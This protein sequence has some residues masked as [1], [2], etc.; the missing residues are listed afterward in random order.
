[1]DLDYFVVIDRRCQEDWIDRDTGNTTLIAT[2]SAQPAITGKFE[3]RY[4]GES[5]L[6]GTDEGNAPL[7]VGLCI[8][9]CDAMLAAYKLGAEEI[10]LYGADFAMSGTTDGQQYALEKYYFD[11]PSYVGL[12][13]RPENLREMQPVAGRDGKLGFINYELWAYACYATAMCCMIEESG[14]VRVRNKSKAGILS[15]GTE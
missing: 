5:F 6:A 2:T 11:L 3:R 4:W 9:M 12:G 15:W 10:W 1:M 13:I 7:R 14:G 8:S